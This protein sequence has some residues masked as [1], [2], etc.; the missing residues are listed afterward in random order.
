MDRIKLLD[1]RNIIGH[2]EGRTYTA[3]LAVLCGMFTVCNCLDL[4]KGMR[5]I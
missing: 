4:E 1:N 5:S 3:L 2:V